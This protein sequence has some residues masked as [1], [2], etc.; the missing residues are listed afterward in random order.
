MDCAPLPTNL[1]CCSPDCLDFPPPRVAYLGF[2]GN[3]VKLE[4]LK[5]RPGAH[6]QVLYTIKKKFKFYFTKSI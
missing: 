2:N 1:S 6:S 4:K 3:Y 5:R